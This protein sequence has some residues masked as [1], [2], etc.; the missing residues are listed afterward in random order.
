VNLSKHTRRLAAAVAIAGS[1]IL[2]P[3]VALAASGGTAA[4]QSAAH[5]RCLAGQ[6]TAWLGEPGSQTAGSTYYQLEISN[7]SGRTCTLYGFPGVSAVRSAM[8]QEGSPAGRV[9]GHAEDLLTLT[10]GST[11]H[12]ILQI[13]DVYNFPPS[14][15]HPVQAF[16][17]R[18]YAPGDFSWHLVGL[19]FAACAKAGPIFLHVSTTIAG[20]GIPGY[21]N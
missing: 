1:A 8:Q 4:P 16:G 6:L 15:C 10:P 2:L 17:L 21:S 9:P 12:V 5:G 13:T 14:A 19:T 18:V 20:T 11:V 3:A 7:I